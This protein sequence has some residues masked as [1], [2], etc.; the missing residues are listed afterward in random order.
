MAETS[1]AVAQQP[2]VVGHQA[3]RL[4]D[5]RHQLADPADHC[6]PARLISRQRSGWAARRTK[7]GGA[8]GPV[9]PTGRNLHQTDLMSTEEV[10][11]SPGSD[12]CESGP[13]DACPHASDRGTSSPSTQSSPSPRSNARARRRPRRSRGDATGHPRPLR[14]RVRRRVGPRTKDASCVSAPVTSRR[15]VRYLRNPTLRK[16]VNLCRR[17][18]YLAIDVLGPSA[19][20][21]RNGR[22]RRHHEDPATTHQRGHLHATTRALGA[23]GGLTVPGAGTASAAVVAHVGPAERDQA[24]ELFATHRVAGCHDDAVHEGR[25]ETAHIAGGAGVR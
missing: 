16:T 15:E 18:G 25:A 8:T 17:C 22:D 7:G 21:G 3:L 13:G 4:T 23:V 14:R 10:F 24:V 1:P 19:S 5:Q 20:P 12:R 2:Q 9:I 11:S 6:R